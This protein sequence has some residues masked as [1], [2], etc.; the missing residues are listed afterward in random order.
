MTIIAVTAA[1]SSPGVSTVAELLAQLGEPERRRVLVDADPA[2]GEWLLRSGVAHEPGLAS[3]AV[4]SRRGLAPG[5]VAEHVQRLGDGLGVI[6]APAAARQAAAALELV[7]ESLVDHL[8]ADGVGA[9]ADCGMLSA[10]SPALPVVRAADLVV[11]VSRSTASGLVHLAPW[12]EQQLSGE[13]LPLAVVLV[14]HGHKARRESAYSEADVAEALGVEVLGTMADD[15]DSAARLFA[16][17]GRLARLANGPLVRSMRPVATAAHARAAPAGARS[18]RG[19][20]PLVGAATARAFDPAP[21]GS[22][23]QRSGQEEGA[24]R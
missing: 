9:V 19:S 13:G 1:K 3:L 18:E 7:G 12:V 21:L 4:A 17:P 23:P 6:V 14:S 8:R 24:E 10:A 15:P 2:G 5:E 20:A 22:S 16:E 11:L